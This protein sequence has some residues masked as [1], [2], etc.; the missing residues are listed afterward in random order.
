MFGQTQQIEQ[1]HQFHLQ[2]YIAD[3]QQL[4]LQSWYCYHL[5]DILLVI[6]MVQHDLRHFH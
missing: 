1:H 2:Y 6:Q 3:Q 5:L 4:K